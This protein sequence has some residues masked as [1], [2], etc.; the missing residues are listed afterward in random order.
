[1]KP[2]NDGIGSPMGGEGKTLEADFT[3]VG[4]K[5]NTKVRSGTAH[6]NPV[7]SLVERDGSARSFHM[8]TVRG[9]NIHAIFEFA[10]FDAKRFH[11]R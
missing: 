2:A 5:P 10:C 4:R 1:M 8:P 7:L 9:D 3:Y 11:D 6:M